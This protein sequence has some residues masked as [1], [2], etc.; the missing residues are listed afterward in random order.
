MVEKIGQLMVMGN[1]TNQRANADE[2]LISIAHLR[3]NLNTRWLSTEDY[4]FDNFGVN[5]YLAY[6]SYLQSRHYE[7]I[8]RFVLIHSQAERD[9]QLEIAGNGVSKFISSLTSDRDLYPFRV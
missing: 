2:L 8:R 1:V 4:P 9:G 7:S 6:M 5:S 3:E